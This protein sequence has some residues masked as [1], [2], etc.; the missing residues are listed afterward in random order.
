MSD[1]TTVSPKH[2]KLTTS[3]EHDVTSKSPVHSER[4]NVA[5]DIVLLEQENKRLQ[6]E[7]DKLRGEIAKWKA[8][9][10]KYKSKCKTLKDIIQ[11]V[12]E[13]MQEP[14]PSPFE[15]KLEESDEDEVEKE[16]ET[17]LIEG[18]PK[19][20]VASQ[21]DAYALRRSQFYASVRPQVVSVPVKSSHNETMPAV[22]YNNR[23]LGISGMGEWRGPMFASPIK[24]S[25]RQDYSSSPTKPAPS[26]TKRP[27]K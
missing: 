12:P 22:G 13:M 6:A 17:S 21:D 3:S 15:L 25:R 4:N 2:D 7:N 24:G 23:D 16:K 18:D 10:D 9:A 1:G 19:T 14:T 27:W 11:G 26:P 8:K 5:D 20:P